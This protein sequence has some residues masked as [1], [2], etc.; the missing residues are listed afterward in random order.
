MEKKYSILLI[1]DEESILHALERLFHRLS[2]CNILT[3][4]DPEKA[5]EIV[6]KQS[7]DLVIS[8]QRMPVMEGVKLLKKVKE[9][10]PDTLRIL[11][12]GYSDIDLLVGAI[13]EGEVFRFVSKPWDNEGLLSMVQFALK[14]RTIMG[15]VGSVINKMQQHV[16]SQAVFKIKTVHDT[17][18]VR[19]RMEV[20]ETIASPERIK[21][22]VNF[23]LRAFTD[24]LEGKDGETLNCVGGVVENAGGKKIVTFDLGNGTVRIIIDFPSAIEN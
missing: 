13:N 17:R 21:R 10:S 24:P 15:V 1:D 23:L 22:A 8:D 7:I 3:E 14:Q 5:L 4:T 18:N 19:I 2:D 12:S 11:L 6:S 16:E 20:D 9:I